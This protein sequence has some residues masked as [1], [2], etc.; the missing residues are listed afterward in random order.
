LKKEGNH[1]VKRT[2]M[3]YSLDMILAIGF[4]IRMTKNEK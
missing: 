3:I 4:R 1:T 2:K